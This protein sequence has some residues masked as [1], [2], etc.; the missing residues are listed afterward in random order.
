[1]YKVKYKRSHRTD[2]DKTLEAKPLCQKIEEWTE[3]GTAIEEVAPMVYTERKDGVLPGYDIRTDR[4]EIARVAK[5]KLEKARIA[6]SESVEKDTTEKE[7]RTEKI[8]NSE[9]GE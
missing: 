2:I 6:K 7:K 8:E 5:E 3:K 4:F 1:M 9:K